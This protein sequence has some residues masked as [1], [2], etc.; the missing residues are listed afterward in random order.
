MLGIPCDPS[1]VP[2][3]LARGDID[4]NLAFFVAEPIGD[5]DGA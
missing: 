3:V 1:D 5:A 2:W 4:E